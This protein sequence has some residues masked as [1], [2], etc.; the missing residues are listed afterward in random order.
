MKQLTI[1][2]PIINGLR[3]PNALHAEDYAAHSWYRFVAAYSPQLVRDLLQEM[4]VSPNEWILDPFSGTGTTVVEAQKNGYQAVAVEAHPFLHF[5]SSTKVNWDVDPVQ[6]TSY[7]R[8]IASIAN[9][10]YG[11]TQV[12]EQLALLPNKEKAIGP[13]LLRKI[14]AIAEVIDQNRSECSDHALLALATTAFKLS[15][16]RLAPGITLKS[17]AREDRPEDAVTQWLS[18]LWAIAQDLESL[19]LLPST[20]QAVILTG[21]SRDLSG[22]IYQTIGAVI[23]SPPYPTELS[24]DRMVRLESV[25]LGYVQDRDSLQQVKRGLLRSNSKNIYAS[26][27]DAALVESNSRV[28]EIAAEIDHR[29][30]ESGSNHGF[31][32]LYADVVR[33]YFGGMKRHLSNLLPILK[34]GAELSYV[35]G[36]QASYFQVY[37][38]TGELILEIAKELGY[39]AI[40]VNPFRNRLASST[41]SDLPEVIVRLRK[42]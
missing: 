25:I 22:I 11:P 9:N 30:K 37:I 17:R 38:P 3:D 20:T 34:D 24:Y 41:Q 33:N 26:D 15:N 1:C 12:D 5:V 14:L 7:G 28:Q 23:C 8:Y 36:D 10:V 4:C 2:D 40:G 29:R 19:K 42:P 6:L 21:D 35:V 39:E 27:N 18:Q 31:S 16:L 32:R 13:K